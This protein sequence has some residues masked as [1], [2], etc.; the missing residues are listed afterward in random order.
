[1][2]R[3]IVTTAVIFAIITLVFL[4]INHKLSL[5]YALFS[6]FLLLICIFY[7]AFRQFIIVL[8]CVF[9]LCIN[10]YSVYNNGVTKYQ[11]TTNIRANIEGIVAECSFN[12]EDVVMYQVNITK[13][14]YPKIEGRKAL[15]YGYNLSSNVGATLNAEVVISFI[16]DGFDW[17][18]EDV[19]FKGYIDKVHN[20]ISKTTY[21][22]FI[23]KLRLSIRNILFENLPYDIATTING[24]TLG[25]RIYEEDEFYAAVKNCG[26]SHIMVVSGLHLAVVCGSL[27]KLLKAFKSPP[28]INAIITLAVTFAFMALCGFT[29]SVLRA[30]IMYIIM[31]VGY[32]LHRDPDALNSLSVAFVIMVII[33][34]FLMCNV[35]FLLSVT[36]TA[37]IIILNPLILKLIRHDK[38]KIKPLKAITEIATVTISAQL[39]TLPICLYCFGWVSRYAVLVNILISYAVTIALISAFL[40]IIM[41]VTPLRPLSK[42][43][44]IFCSFVTAYF[45]KIIMFF[46]NL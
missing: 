20:I 30:G 3:P 5:L 42:I 46:G 19:Y 44:F 13:S 16:E 27:Y 1:M 9:I 25:E 24:I 18:S 23:Y 29:P 28:F 7:K 8:I 35:G 43:L 31:L 40:G 38:W 26:V 2:K 11:D 34:P 4:K 17:Y 21:K 15:L 33:N 39:A 6:L 41:S 22:N 32:L 36:S 14:T 45:N 37:G 12:S 10:F